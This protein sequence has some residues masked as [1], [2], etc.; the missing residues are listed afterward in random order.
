MEGGGEGKSE[1]D[2]SGHR[3]MKERKGVIV[4]ACHC[5]VAMGGSQVILGGRGQIQEYYESFQVFRD[6]SPTFCKFRFVNSYTTII[7]TASW[8]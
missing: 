3:F 8:I 6:N 1:P 2:G 7:L 4:P 5:Q